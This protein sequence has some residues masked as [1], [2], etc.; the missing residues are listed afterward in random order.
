MPLRGE[1]AAVLRLPAGPELLVEERQHARHVLFRMVQAGHDPAV[2]TSALE[3]R[4]TELV[5]P[6]ELPDELTDGN[7]D[8]RIDPPVSRRQRPRDVPIRARRVS[9]DLPSSLGDQGLLDV[10]VPGVR[11][12][13]PRV[14]H[15]LEL[16]HSRRDRV[17]HGGELVEQRLLLTVETAF[18]SLELLEFLVLGHV[19]ARASSPR[20]HRLH[21]FGEDLHAVSCLRPFRFLVPPLLLEGA[22]LRERGQHLLGDLWLRR[23][24]LGVEGVEHRITIERIEEDLEIGLRDGPV[25]AFSKD[26]HGYVGTPARVE[27]DGGAD[28]Q[29]ETTLASHPCLHVG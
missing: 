11:F 5:L 7:T 9:K 8:P 14:A 22:N 24:R 12:V 15:G 25:R 1:V 21:L 29:K 28:D 26:L 20:I 17:L 16:V 27:R 23:G 3:V 2:F 6:D 4:T 10:K 18:H 13:F 19:L